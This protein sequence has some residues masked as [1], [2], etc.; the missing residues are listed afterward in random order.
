MK[1]ISA[2]GCGL[3]SFVFVFVIDTYYKVIPY[4]HL[5]SYITLWNNILIRGEWKL[6][7]LKLCIENEY[8]ILPPVNYQN[9]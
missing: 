4:R 8:D 5:D 3:F 7:Y 9:N 2:N 6:E 1:Y